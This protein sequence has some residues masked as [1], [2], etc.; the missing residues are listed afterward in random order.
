MQVYSSILAL[1]E[2][3]LAP[4]F[5]DR[6]QDKLKPSVRGFGYWCWKPQIIKQTLEQMNE[7][8][9]LH[10]CDAGC[11]LNLAG[12]N[13]LQEYLSMVSSNS[14]GFLAF[15]AKEPADPFMHDGRKLLDLRDRFWIKGDALDYFKVRSRI[16]IIDTQTIGAGIIFIR[17]NK[18]TIDIVKHWLDIYYKNFSLVDDSVSISPNLNGFIEHR[19]D[20]SIFSILCK[21][22][23]IETISAY[24]Y[25]Y[26][27]RS[28]LTKPDWSVLKN[29]PIW[30][31]RK[32]DFGF[33]GN[34]KVWG[35]TKY[36]ALQRKFIL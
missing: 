12:K 15:Q 27:S 1:D 3:S 31:M 33:W 19:H 29:Y 11:Y 22:S 16:D 17:K 13:R 32:K 26:P 35:L 7:G 21:L 18:N 23:D 8:D 24:E 9:V 34:I 14:I 30:A 4:E 5:S 10:Y 28:D 6:F 20:Q 2:R 25:W 36:H